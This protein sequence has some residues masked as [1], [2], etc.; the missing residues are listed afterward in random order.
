MPNRITPNL[1]ALV[2]DSITSLCPQGFHDFDSNHCAH[3]VSHD[4]GYRF[5]FLCHNMPDTEI[6]TPSGVC[7]RVQEL[8][9]HCPQVGAW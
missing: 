8:L 7:V 4:G 9:P 5:G 1:D 6:A 3:F 2:G